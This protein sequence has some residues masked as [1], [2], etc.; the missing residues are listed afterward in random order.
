MSHKLEVGER[1]SLASHYCTSKAFNISYT[2]L[3]R[4]HG[5]RRYMHLNE[6]RFTAVSAVQTASSKRTVGVLL[7]LSSNR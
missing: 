4:I 3:T 7:L 1:R 2:K 5:I 6:G